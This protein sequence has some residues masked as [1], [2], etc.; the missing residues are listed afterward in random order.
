MPEIKQ[1]THADWLAKGER[2]FGPDK[3][4]WAFKCPICETRIEVR[5]W[6]KAGSKE[7]AVAFSCIGRYLDKKQEAFSKK[8][9]V[10]GKP[11]NYTLGGLFKIHTL[12]VI[13]DDGL[14]DPIF[15]FY[16]QEER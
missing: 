16:E 2:L 6:Q 9:V 1:I 13:F 14:I 10:K 4:L 8:K 3:L 5:D 15:E 7:G 11:C 12:E